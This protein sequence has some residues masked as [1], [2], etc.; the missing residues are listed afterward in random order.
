MDT[1]KPLRTVPKQPIDNRAVPWPE[2]DRTEFFST[3]SDRDRA[4]VIE[5]P[6]TLGAKEAKVLC[7]RVLA[8]GVSQQLPILLD[9]SRVK[10]IDSRGVKTLLDCL[11]YAHRH[12]G[13]VQV[14]GISPEAEVVL[15]LLG[16]ERAFGITRSESQSGESQLK[17]RVH[18]QPCAAEYS[19]QNAA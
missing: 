18:H 14:I 10:Q 19:V 1:M 17:D 15:E 13:T 12:D 4:T 8:L 7:A 2:M 9:M 16:L 11:H 5:V 6:S 3:T